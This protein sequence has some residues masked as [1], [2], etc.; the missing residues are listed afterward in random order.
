MKRLLFSMLCA[1]P[2]LAGALSGCGERAR[3]DQTA[4][5]RRNVQPP[6]D[7]AADPF[8]APG[9]KSG[10]QASWQAHMTQ[11]AQNQNEYLRAN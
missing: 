8:V 7:A 9:W 6:W 2:L 3:S 1:L 11:R 5:A 10:D 4:S